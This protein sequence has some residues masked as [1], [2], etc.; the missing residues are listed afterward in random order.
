MILD[1]LSPDEVV[2]VVKTL[3][4]EQVHRAAGKY[5]TAL[6]I[7]KPYL[8]A[9]LSD[10]PTFL[11]GIAVG[12]AIADACIERKIEMTWD[13]RWRLNGTRRF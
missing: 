11:T 2:D 13:A 3:N 7:A 9:M 8:T 4:G 10:K 5:T 6:N 12:L 1:M